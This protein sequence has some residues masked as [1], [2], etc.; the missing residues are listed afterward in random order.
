MATV[1]LARLVSCVACPSD[2]LEM[3]LDI[4]G[5]EYEVCSTYLHRVCASASDLRWLST[6]HGRCCAT[7]LPA[8]LRAA[9][10]R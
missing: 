5:A 3:H 9:S 7:C 2:R 4:E 1:D 8:A 10:V 6:Y